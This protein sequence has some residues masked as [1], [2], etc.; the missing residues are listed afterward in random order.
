MSRR[1]KPNKF[2]IIGLVLIAVVVAVLFFHGN[3]G[4]S[5]TTHPEYYNFT[6]GYVFGLPKNYSVD[7]QSVPGIPLVY[8]GKKSAKTLEDIYNQEGISFG[9]ISDY[10]SAKG[11]KDYINKTTIPALQK[12]LSTNDIKVKLGKQDGQEIGRVTVMKDNKQLRFIYIKAGQHP[13]AMVS[14]QETAAV[15]D[16]EK[17][18]KDVEKSDL[19][20]QADSLKDII[21]SM[22]QLIKDQKS[23]NIYNGASSD[24]KAKT[25]EASLASALKAAEPYTSGNITF[26]GLTYAPSDFT[27]GMRLI[28]LDDQDHPAFGSISFKKNGDK[29]E[30]Q[31]ITLPSPGQ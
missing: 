30:L 25:A 3:G 11:L 21:K 17:S 13:V 8:S 7:E 20:D 1:L 27:A 16:I 23:S 14:Q 2:I 15:R 26:S 19:K 6:G 24:L 5:V 12:S 18:L 29:W 4:K 10:N 31:S 9:G 22:A 28:K